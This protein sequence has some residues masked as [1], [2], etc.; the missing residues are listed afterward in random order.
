[1]ETLSCTSEIRIPRLTSRGCG[2]WLHAEVLERGVYLLLL[3]IGEL[4]PRE[5]VEDAKT[6]LQ[7]QPT[8][9]DVGQEAAARDALSKISSASEERAG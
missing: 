7:Q 1:M 5:L 2:K 3:F 8:G 9:L 4:G 6:H